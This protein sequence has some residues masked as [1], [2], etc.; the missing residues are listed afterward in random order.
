[1]T[2][3]PDSHDSGDPPD[4]RQTPEDRGL[5]RLRLDAEPLEVQLARYRAA[6]H[7]LAGVTTSIAAAFFALFAA[8]DRPGVGLAVAALLWLPI[9]GVSWRDHRRLSRDVE[10][11]LQERATL[12]RDQNP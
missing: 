4:A 11:Q 7:V 12:H 2:M 5:G 10:R 3:Y 6:F 8:F 9:V 1:M